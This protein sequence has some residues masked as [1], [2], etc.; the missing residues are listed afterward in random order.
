MFNTKPRYNLFAVII[1]VATI[2]KITF[3][4]GF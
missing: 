3:P 4:W 2:D 1:Y